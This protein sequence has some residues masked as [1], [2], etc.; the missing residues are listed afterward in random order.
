MTQYIRELSELLS[1]ITAL[2]GEAGCPWDK[3][4]TPFSLLKHLKSECQELDNAIRN[5]D[6]VNVCEE[7]GDLLY[8]IIMIAEIH[9]D[10]DEFQL[11]DVIR[12]VNKKLIRRHPHV[13]AGKPYENEEQLTAQWNAIKAE[14]K[15]KNT[16]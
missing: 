4:Q 11:S 6:P 15:K 9:H 1:T 12:T 7:L 3:R 14:E 8:I 10:H 13:F 5:D 2:R 16:L